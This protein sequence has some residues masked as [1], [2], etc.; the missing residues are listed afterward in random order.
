MSYLKKHFVLRR[1]S[2]DEQKITPVPAPRWAKS[3]VIAGIIIIILIGAAIW[4]FSRAKQPTY[5]FAS[6]T[7][8][9]VE[10]VVSVTG[11]VKPAE[12]VELA[13]ETGGRVARV[14]AAV[15]DKVTAGQ[16]LVALDNRDL[17]A[18]LAEVKANAAAQQAKLDELRRGTRP[19]ELTVYE[20]KVANA[21]AAFA[22]ARRNMEDKLRDA[23]TKSDDAVRNRVDQF[24]SSPRSSS[25]QLTF[26]LSDNQLK[27]DI[28]WGRF[29][30][31]TKLAA[32]EKSLAG[33]M[34]TSNLNVLNDEAVKSLDAV[35]SFL[36]K[37]ALAVNSLTANSTLTQTKIDGWRAD[38]A[39]ART[40]V[41][42]ATSNLSAA[43][44]KLKTAQSALDLAK[45]ELSLARSG[46][47]PETI[48]AQEAALAQ[49]EASVLSAEAKLSKTV[50]Y[51]PIGGTVTQKNFKVGEMIAAN[52]TAIAVISASSFEVEVNVPE[53][54]IA[55]VSLHD[56]ADI[57]LDAYGSGAVFKALVVKID[58][59]E[60]MVEG[61]A[62][63][64]TTL[65]FADGDAR[66]KSGMTANI[67]ILTERRENVIVLPRRAVVA[68]GG[69]RYV[70][71]LEANGNVREVS[72]QTG[73][74]GSDGNVE[75]L[76]GVNEGD[77]VIVFIKN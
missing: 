40:N 31:E 77:K 65:Q 66:I 13:F 15:G 7:R 4:Y 25:P 48:R 49:A 27:S 50:L 35:K 67:D 36:D 33:I 8:G 63:Y 70:R 53:A 41:N 60:T 18:Q 42:T 75:I 10:Q 52:A 62:T 22:D 19:E 69:E 21:E 14:Y 17:A 38:I 2:D 76:S 34:A 32:W 28:E 59:A 11:R 61:V 72:V 73:L 6:A 44:E 46:S 3:P 5:E 55:K 43:A 30:V 12:S 64:K 37:V 20:V 57:T 51:S 54:D 71:E 26:T 68:Q 45:Q 29:G 39:T 9:K 47:T 16:A 56:T 23:Y 58:P 1:H 24:V 74:Y